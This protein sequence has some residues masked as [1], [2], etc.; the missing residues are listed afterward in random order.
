[1]EKSHQNDGRRTPPPA[2]IDLATPTRKD[3]GEQML[4]TD[5][6]LSTSQNRG[7][8]SDTYFRSVIEK[9]TELPPILPLVH[10][11]D[12]HTLR[13]IISS[14][15]IKPTL[16]PVFNEKLVYYFYGR[17][18]YRLSD[19]GLTFNTSSVYPACLIIQPEEVKSIT[20][21][22]PFD[23]GAYAAGLYSNHLHKNSKQED[24]LLGSNYPFVQKF[25]KFFYDNN[26]NYFDGK[27]TLEKSTLQPCAYELESIYSL[28][29]VTHGELFDSRCYTIE[30]QSSV[31]IEINSTAL[32]AIVIPDSIA[33]DTALAAYL[34]ENEIEAITYSTSRVAPSH[35]TPLVIS[36]VREF[37]IDRGVIQ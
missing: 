1:M 20:R 28:I 29:N 36:K 23:S 22:F 5:K 13:E 31:S 8:V 24:Y 19:K 32:K 16:C 14:K 6:E 3:Q 7:L 21:I 37:Y 12:C 26:Q 9:V 18:S 15:I 17:P 27:S 33:N 30:L 25:V 35:L 11:C 10:T 2:R 4:N 34:Y